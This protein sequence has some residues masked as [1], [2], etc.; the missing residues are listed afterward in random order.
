MSE[1]GIGLRQASAEQEPRREPGWV[2]AVPGFQGSSAGF[3]EPMR[4]FTEDPA[5]VTH[6]AGLKCYLCP[7]PFTA[8][9]QASLTFISM[10]PFSR[11]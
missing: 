1:G 8:K 5:S 9:A 4:R 10:N 3:G 7:R 11:R 2:G 6:V